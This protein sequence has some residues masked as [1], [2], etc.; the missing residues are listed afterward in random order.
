ME[1]VQRTDLR[2]ILNKNIFTFETLAMKKC[3]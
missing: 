3:S 2:M 1:D